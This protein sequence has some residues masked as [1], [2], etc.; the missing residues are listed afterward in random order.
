[1][2]YDQTQCADPWDVNWSGDMDESTTTERMVSYLNDSGI[3][4]INTETS[5][6]SNGI[7][8][9]ACIC[10]TGRSIEITV[11]EEFES[12]LNQLG[13]TAN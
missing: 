4:V 8:C 1:M 9:L 3:T 2:I 10:L 6:E 5:Q 7:V 12:E 11:N 13:F